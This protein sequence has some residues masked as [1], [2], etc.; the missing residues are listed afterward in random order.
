MEDKWKGKKKLV[1]LHSITKAI[2]NDFHKQSICD[3]SINENL[4]IIKTSDKLIKS[5]ISSL[6]VPV[7]ISHSVKKYF[8]PQHNSF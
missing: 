8:Y 4:R 2:Q 7:T 1:N 3:T 5:D 6:P